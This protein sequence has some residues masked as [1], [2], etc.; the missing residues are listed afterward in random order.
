MYNYIY[1]YADPTHNY[2]STIYPLILSLL[3][4]IRYINE[5]DFCFTTNTKNK[6]S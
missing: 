5:K 4:K 3:Y 6:Q 1:I 2:T